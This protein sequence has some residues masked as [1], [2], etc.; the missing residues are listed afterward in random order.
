[1]YPE[2]RNPLGYKVLRTWQQAKEIFEATEEFCATLPSKHPKTGQYLTDI[3]DQ[4]IRSGRSQVRNIEEGYCRNST[5]EYIDFLGFALGSLEELLS[6]FEYC[7]EGNLGDYDRAIKGL[8]LCRGQFKMLRNQ[9]E[10]LK[11]K[12]ISEGQ[13]SSN[14][15][16]RMAL[17]ENSKREKEFDEYLKSILDK[18]KKAKNKDSDS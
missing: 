10:K 13:V 1:M 2:K 5:K 3:K 17:L 4:M 6:D 7:V 15:R 9:I 18:N 14:D 12:M 8:R 11:D 16:A